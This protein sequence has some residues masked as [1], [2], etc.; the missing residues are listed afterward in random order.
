M[1]LAFYS[2]HSI[3]ITRPTP[4]I[5]TKSFGVSGFAKAVKIVCQRH[6]VVPQVS[7]QP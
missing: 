2:R 7:A 1:S 4:S 5:T 3:V 6:V